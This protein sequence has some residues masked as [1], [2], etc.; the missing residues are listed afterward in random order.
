VVRIENLHLV[1]TYAGGGTSPGA[2][3]AGPNISLGNVSHVTI[4]GNVLEGAQGDAISDHQQE[5]DGGAG[6]AH[7]VLVA[8]NTLRRPYRCC[9]SL[10]EVV[11]RWA[12]LDNV[13]E[14]EGNDSS[15]PF[16]WEPWR[17]ESRVTNVELA[18]NRVTLWS[19][20]SPESPPLHVNGWFDPHPGGGIYTHHNY[21]AWPDNVHR[22][23]VGT[24]GKW[25]RVITHHNARG[26]APP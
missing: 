14:K 11:D 9:L 20:A 2:Q 25:E 18:W 22:D 3:S 26:A 17:P 4:A 19:G 6:G 24:N 10:V 12:I 23:F 13:C 7:D 5:L 1:G 21:G 16:D 15:S 8:G